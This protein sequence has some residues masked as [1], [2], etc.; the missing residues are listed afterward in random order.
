M[1]SDLRNFDIPERM[2]RAVD[3][4]RERLRR[5]T[6][7][8]ENAGIEYALIGGN[9]VAAWVV[10]V[11][12]T[13]VRNTRDV[14]I[15]VNRADFDRVKTELEKQGFH[16]RHSAGVDMFLDGE[17]SKARDAI[18]IIFAGEKVRPD[19]IFPA[20]SI[21]E[22]CYLS[23]NLRVLELKALVRMKLTSYRRRDQVHLLDLISVG[24][25]GWDDLEDYPAPLKERLRD[26]LEHPE[27]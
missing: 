18:H 27:D 25:I 3:K 14:D 15:L 19:Y 22:A 5:A 16:Y 26:L 8:L 20:P 7:T 2:T 10:T 13:A 12:E 17:K 11:D 23:E 24:L 21:K 4:V 1:K 9:A 6:K